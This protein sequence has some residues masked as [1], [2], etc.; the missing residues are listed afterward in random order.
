MGQKRRYRRTV[1]WNDPG[2]PWKTGLANDGRTKK[3]FGSLQPRLLSGELVLGAKI[4]A[5]NHQLCLTG[6]LTLKHTKVP[7]AGYLP[8]IRSAQSSKLGIEK[9]CRQISNSFVFRGE[10]IDKE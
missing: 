4:L 2:A 9:K 1:F 3:G 8:D 6:A 5:N 7:I 10:Q